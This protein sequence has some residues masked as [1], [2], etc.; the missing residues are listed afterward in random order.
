MD[1]KQPSLCIIYRFVLMAVVPCYLNAQVQEVWSN[2]SEASNNSYSPSSE[3]LFK[4]GTENL[5]VKKH[6]KAIANTHQESLYFASNGGFHH[7]NTS[8]HLFVKDDLFSNVNQT[9]RHSN[10]SKLQ[11]NTFESA[12]HKP[13][14]TNCIPKTPHD[15]V[16]YDLKYSNLTHSGNGVEILRNN[17][18]ISSVKL[19]RYVAKT[20]FHGPFRELHLNSEDVKNSESEAISYPTKATDSSKMDSDIADL[21]SSHNVSGQ[22]HTNDMN[23]TSRRLMLYARS[24]DHTSE[25][26]ERSLRSRR[27]NRRNNSTTTNKMGRSATP[28]VQS[29]N[30]V[31]VNTSALHSPPSTR[32]SR[33]PDLSLPPETESDVPAS[34]SREE[35]NKFIAEMKASRSG[36]LFDGSGTAENCQ[37]SKNEEGICIPLTE[38][39]EAMEKLRREI[40][41]ICRWIGDMPVVCCPKISKPRKLSVPGCGTRIVRGL[42]RMVRQVPRMIPAI[43]PTKSDK[44]PAVAGGVE[45]VVGAWPWMAGIY[46]RNFGIENFLCGAAVINEKHLVTAAHCFQTSGRGRVQTARYVVRV[47]SIKAME[48]SLYLIDSIIIHPEY[49]RREHYNDIA[50]IR[51]KDS[52]DFSTNVRPICLPNS[53]EIRG[54]K[55]KGRDVT[56]T[57][58]G[59]LEFG[60][61]RASILRE[62]TVKVMDLPSCNQSY[63]D[64]RGTTI[65][66]GLTSQFI[67]AGVPEGGKDACQRDSGGPLMLFENGAWHLVGVVSFGY[68]C[69]QAGYPG[70]YTRITSYL[71]WLEEVTAG[72]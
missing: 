13:C 30:H 64:M 4:K 72:S 38:C 44:K 36:I 35:F 27:V 20:F 33:L 55:L 56:V 39:K 48:G 28:N 52:M 37:T 60:G 29:E 21:T 61:Q 32:V 19:A 15:N 68:Q 49:K 58:W 69:A 23:N 65:P 62:V 59:D 12:V 40:P 6:S 2:D 43:P 10:L 42:N 9:E 47:G 66:Q 22:N 1:R 26:A 24:L 18:S 25:V 57:G 41:R 50:V 54:K 17:Q 45:S 3:L 70:V 63:A 51:L 11:E 71:Q 8:V 5:S 7:D 67:C 53:S 34:I 14:S 46:T 16:I 31:P